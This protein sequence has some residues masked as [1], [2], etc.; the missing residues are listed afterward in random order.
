[1]KGVKF[2]VTRTKEKMILCC[3]R[4]VKRRVLGGFGGMPRSKGDNC[5]EFR[6]FL[7]HKLGASPVYN[8]YLGRSARRGTGKGGK[9]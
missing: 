9:E 3:E 5:C 1:M 6:I 4:I 2:S 8:L 7:K